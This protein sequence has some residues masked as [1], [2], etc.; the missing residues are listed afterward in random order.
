MPVKP[1]VRYLLYQVP[2]WVL[3]AAV[4][5]LLTEWVGLPL[6]AAAAALAVMVLKDLALYPVTRRSYEPAPHGPAQLVGEDGVAVETLAPIGYVR[7]RGELW[8]AEAAEPSPIPAGSR[9]R[10]AAIRDL[11]LLVVRCSDTE[12]GHH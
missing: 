9:V 4:L 5:G 1:L 11:T 12:I 6:V 3:A 7:I 8:R 2:G 10:V